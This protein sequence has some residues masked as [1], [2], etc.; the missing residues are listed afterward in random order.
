MFLV[1]VPLK[2]CSYSK[3]STLLMGLS[4]AW[5]FLYSVFFCIFVALEFYT[6]LL[7][8]LIFFVAKGFFG[9]GDGSGEKRIGA[10]IRIGK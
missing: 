1:T 10:T 4:L 5:F 8:L 3:M 6:L 2:W 9:G 7:F